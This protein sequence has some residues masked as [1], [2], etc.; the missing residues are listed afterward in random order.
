MNR[1]RLL[2]LYVLVFVTANCNSPDDYETV[3]AREL[4]RPDT[5]HTLFFNYKLGMSR[6]AFYDSSWALN[7]Q[8][9]VSHGPNNRNVQYKLPD[10]LSHEATMLY[11]P[12]FENDRISQMRVRFSYDGWA[13]WNRHLWAD[14]LIFEIR[15]LMEAWYGKGFLTN[16]VSVPMIGITNEF[17]K[18]DANRQIMIRRDSDR[19]VLVTITDLRAIPSEEDE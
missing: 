9:L 13:P 4:A 6:Q 16:Q 5:I 7:R 14:S 12:D 10:Q 2:F 15:D 11:Y 8:G 18:I 17:V 19:E 3:L 1:T